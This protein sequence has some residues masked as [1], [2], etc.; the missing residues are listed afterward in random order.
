ME[1][2]RWTSDEEGQLLHLRDHEHNNFEDISTVLGR[3]PGATQARYN[4]IKQR[5]QSSY[6]DWTPETDQSIID[7]RRRR[8]AIKDIAN[9]MNL[10]AEAVAER[11][12]T[13][14]R[15]KVVPEEVLAIWR[16]KENVIFTPEEDETILKV[17]MQMRDDEQLI[18]IVKFKGK[19]QG[20]IRERRSELVNRHS[21]LYLK[22]LGIGDGK[23]NESD[24]LK[25]ALG[26]SKYS[27]MK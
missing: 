11:W 13:L 27:W 14:Q 17:W 20:D 10:S 2:R 16:R 12:F 26:K 6:I 8:L 23:D 3:S 15:Q 21:P 7:G 22:M 1:L 5:Q 4:I 19:S 18:R 25:V 9:E 24:A